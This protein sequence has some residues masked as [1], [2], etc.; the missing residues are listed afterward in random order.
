MLIPKK[1]KYELVAPSDGSNEYDNWRVRITKGKFKNTVFYY[2]TITPTEE[3]LKYSFHIEESEFKNLTKENKEFRKV[4]E[5]ILIDIMKR[6]LYGQSY[7]RTPDT[8]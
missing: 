5:R 4:V 8:E 7:D 2:D 6:E 3:V 1:P